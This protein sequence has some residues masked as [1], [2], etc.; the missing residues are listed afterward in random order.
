VSTKRAL[1]RVRPPDER[2]AEE[3]AWAVVSSAYR[4][5]PVVA[6]RR[7]QWRLAAVPALVALIAGLALSPAGAA[8]SRL[9][10]RALGVSHAGRALYSLPAPG[11]LLIS[12]SG[13]TWTIAADGSA[14]RLGAWPQASWSPHGLYIAVAQ[15]DRLA[16][17]DPHGVTRWTL[18]RPAVSD[19][20]WY[21]PSGFRVAYRSG[22]QLRVVA[23]DGT[24][25]HL[26]AGKVAPVAPA[27]RPDHTYQL[28]YVDSRGAL[29]VRDAD[30]GE[31][32]W[33]AGAGAARTLDWSADGGRL[34]VLTRTS[35]RIYDGQ[36]GRM[37]AQLAMPAG[38]P[39]LDGSL[40]PDGRTLTV[41]RGGTAQDVAIAELNG[42]RPSL[43]G[44][45]TGDGVRQAI[46]SPDGRW[47][48]VSWP[49]AD[50]WVFVH[51]TGAPR[52][53]AVSRIAQQFAT[54]SPVGL[55]PRLDGWCCTAHGPR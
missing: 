12:G 53:A 27:W 47:L 9:I 26:L 4:E 52:I 19:P 28:A 17:I 42:P 10:Q 33:S 38:A 49:A 43:R 11:S 41:V 30:S 1:N 29:V 18:A 44:V 24:G 34:L 8:V 21:S 14:R 35:A 15:G 3:R 32:I 39:L 22:R 55:F 6:T 46:W 54:G 13:G 25:D 36:V 23:G 20:R 31:L 50:E 2:G 48:L 16:V 51:V 40:S 45:L 5:R 7:P 37:I